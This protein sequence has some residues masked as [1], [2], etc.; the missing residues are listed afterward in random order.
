MPEAAKVAT[1]VYTKRAKKT[2]LAPLW[3]GPFKINRRIGDS[4][5]ELIVAHYNDGR[6]R[7]ELRHWNTCFPAPL[8]LETTAVRKP[9]GRKPLNAKAPEF[10]PSPQCQAPAE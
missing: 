1:H 10:K 9:L 3:D 2:P 5:L 4:T 6:P 8:D 7:L